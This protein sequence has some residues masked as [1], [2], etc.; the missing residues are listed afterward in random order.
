MT[1]DDTKEAMRR[2]FEALGT[3]SF[4][5]VVD[6]NVTWTVTDTGHVVSGAPHVR[7]HLD[8]LHAAM[9]NT[10]SRDLVTNDGV[11]I[12]EGECEVPGDLE[13]PTAFCVVYEVA[14]GQVV[15]MRLYGRL[16]AALRAAT[17]VEPH[18]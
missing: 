8:A 16:E 11:A 17:L 6:P 5:D 1:I 13:T 12:L 4:S 2:Y 15:A 9:L 7:R 14:H 10:R 18:A 3:E